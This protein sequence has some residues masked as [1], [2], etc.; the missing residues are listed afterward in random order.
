MA[1]GVGLGCQLANERERVGALLRGPW[2]RSAQEG[3]GACAR[4]FGDWAC[5]MEG[6]G[7]GGE[8]R[9]LAGF[10]WKKGEEGRAGPLGPKE[11]KGDFLLLFLILLF[12]SHF[13]IISKAFEFI[14]EFFIKT[15]HH[16]NSYAS[17]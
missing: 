8:K 10:S 15:T 5:G 17:A 12:Q 3:E 13:Q 7:C 11:R 9:E 14:F 1:Q 16:N 2:P 4:A 6:G